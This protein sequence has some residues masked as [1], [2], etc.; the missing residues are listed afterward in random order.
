MPAN[1]SRIKTSLVIFL[2]EADNS[3]QVTN[4]NHVNCSKSNSIHQRLGFI[5]T[6]HTRIERSAKVSLNGSVV[7]AVIFPESL[8]S[9]RSPFSF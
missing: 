9:A 4:Q 5:Q 2:V 3:A 7:Y 1:D 6:E 8:Y